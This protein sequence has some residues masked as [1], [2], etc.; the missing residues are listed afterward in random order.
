ML[1]FARAVLDADRLKEAG[2]ASLWVGDRNLAAVHPVIGYG[3][4]GTAVPEEL[5]AAA[6]PFVLLGVAAGATRRVLLGGQVLVAPLC[7]PLQPARSLTTIDLVSGG[8][9][10]PGFGVGWSPEEYQAAGLDF[11]HRGARMDELLDALE[12]LWTT[13]PAHYEGARLS[14]PPHH[15]PFKPDRRPRPPRPER[16]G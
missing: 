13:D 2:A 6:D 16:G 9:L 8:R 1:A 15:S 5:N 14:V 4:Q 11:T 7:P 12:A 3:G 10:V